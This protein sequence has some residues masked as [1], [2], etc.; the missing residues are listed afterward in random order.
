MVK[1]GAG[2]F[3]CAAL[4]EGLGAF[5]VKAGAGLFCLAEGLGA[6]LVKTRASS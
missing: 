5:L 6:S 3:C 1:A 4:A 2:L